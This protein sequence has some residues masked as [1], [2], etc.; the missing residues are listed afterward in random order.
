MN[1]DSSQVRDTA[2]PFSPSRQ[3]WLLIVMLALLNMYLFMYHPRSIRF[4]VLA[5]PFLLAG[6][7]LLKDLRS[8]ALMLPIAVTFGNKAIEYGQ[9]YTS[10]ATLAVILVFFAFAVH[11]L[12]GFRDNPPY[13]LPFK[14]VGLAYLAQLASVF[15]TFYHHDNL[16]WNVIREGHKHFLGALLLP[17]VYFW[18]GRGEWLERFLKVLVLM[19]FIMCLYGIYQYTSGTLDN[20]GELASGFDLAGRVFSTIAGGPNSY[21]GVLELL[22]PSTLAASFF[23]RERFWKGLAVITTILGILNTLYTFSRGGFLTVTGACLVYL[24]YHYRKRIWVPVLS[25]L[26]FTGFVASNSSE[27]ERQLTVFSNPRELMLD[28]S[29]LH[30]YVSYMGFIEE[31]EKDPL[32]GIGWGSAE[33]YHGR[34]ALYGFWEVRHMDSVDK[35]SRFGG[36]NSLILEMPLKGGALSAISLILVFSGGCIAAARTLRNRKTAQLGFGFVCG[37]AGFGVHQLFDN[38][39]PW[40]QTGA[41]F[42]TIFAL[43]TAM[44]FPCCMKEEY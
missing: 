15:A 7:Y 16:F 12:A 38:L 44:A 2:V 42:W 43:L 6:L 10:P 13:P 29:L 31:I 36:L 21:S 39:I 27:F 40:P 9:F 4:T 30:R 3:T 28:T 14:L 19:L 37:L 1:T 33:Y 11:R 22:V 41:F 20:L 17:V 32:E 25:F 26:V 34:T 18:F 5:F 23:F 35:I 8:W 24:I